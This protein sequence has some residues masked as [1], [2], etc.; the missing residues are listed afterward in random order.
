MPLS[1]WPGSESSFTGPWECLRSTQSWSTL[2]PGSGKMT[3]GAWM[4]AGTTGIVLGAGR[5]GWGRGLRGGLRGAGTYQGVEMSWLLERKKKSEFGQPF[6]GGQGMWRNGLADGWSGAPS[7]S[8][9]SCDRFVQLPG[10]F[11]PRVFLLQG[12]NLLQGL[13]SGGTYDS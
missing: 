12:Q 13:W 2:C 7:P 8:R 9:N 3:E 6:P 5:A 4:R 1:P 11:P 10:L